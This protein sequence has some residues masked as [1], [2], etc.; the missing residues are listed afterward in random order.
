MKKQ[1]IPMTVALAMTWMMAGCQ[2][3]VKTAGVEN[4]CDSSLAVLHIDSAE[5]YTTW[6]VSD[7][8]LHD[9]SDLQPYIKGVVQVPKAEQAPVLARAVME[10]V[11]EDCLDGEDDG[12][13]TDVK[14]MVDGYVKRRTTGDDF[15]TQGGGTLDFSVRKVFEND[16]LVT[17]LYENYVYML[18]AAHGMGSVKGATF[19]KTDGKIFGWNMFR[20]GADLQPLLNQGLKKYFNVTTD[21][22]LDENLLVQDDLYSAH[23]LP[24]PGTAPWIDKDGVVLMYQSYEVAPYSGGKPTV[25]IDMK[26][27]EKYLTTTMNKLLK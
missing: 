9:W 22:E 4:M 23:Y 10:W 25:V 18:G 8:D 26:D 2:K 13:M 11:N 3:T 24:H 5:V 27:A 20:H 12:D 21:E 16:K 1:L 19:R 7:P 15:K 17:F 6:A 14:A